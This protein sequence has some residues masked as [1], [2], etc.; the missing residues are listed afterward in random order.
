MLASA[1]VPAAAQSLVALRQYQNT[2]TF[3]LL[4]TTN[5]SEV[6]GG[7]TGGTIVAYVYDGPGTGLIP[8]YRYFN[9]GASHHFMTTNWGEL[10]GGG[11]G[12]DL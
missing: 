7:W 11:E 12:L 5:P 2:S 10:G 6:G 9:S 1:P 8:M 3:D 4:Y